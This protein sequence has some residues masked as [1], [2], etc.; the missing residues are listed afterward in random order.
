MSEVTLFI[1]GSVVFAITVYGTVMGAGIALSRGTE[2]EEP[3]NPG[4]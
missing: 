1:I 4:A 3:L 2:E